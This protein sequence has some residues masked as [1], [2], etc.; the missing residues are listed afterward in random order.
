MFM[1]TCNKKHNFVSW[2]VTQ[3]FPKS[4]FPGGYDN[5][6]L[7]SNRG[8]SLLHYLTQLLH[9]TQE[10]TLKRHKESMDGTR[11]MNWTWCFKCH[12]MDYPVTQPFSVILFPHQKPQEQNWQQCYLHKPPR[13]E[14]SHHSKKVSKSSISH[15]FLKEK[16]KEEENK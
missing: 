2:L 5:R 8:R 16:K 11:E 12:C 14:Q 9:S 3:L 10:Q 1:P 4:C 13:L 15:K 7:H 6:S